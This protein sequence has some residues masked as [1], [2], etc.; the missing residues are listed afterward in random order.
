M[1][2]L[3]YPETKLSCRK[4]ESLPYYNQI[5]MYIRKLNNKKHIKR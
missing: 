2:I 3:F 1:L 4:T 5:E